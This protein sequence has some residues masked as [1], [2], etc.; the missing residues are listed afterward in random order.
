MVTLKAM[1]RCE[2]A[3]GAQPCESRDL[4]FAVKREINGLAA[5]ERLRER[6]TQFTA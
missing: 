4:L 3:A 2:R 6:S 1:L 5:Q